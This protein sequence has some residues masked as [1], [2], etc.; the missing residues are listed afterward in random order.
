MKRFHLAAAGLAY[1]LA[2]AAMAV[3]TPAQYNNL[4]SATGSGTSWSTSFAAYCTT[5]TAGCAAGGGTDY[6][7]TMTF[8]SNGGASGPAVTLSAWGSTT[9]STSSTIQ[10]ASIQNYGNPNG[11]GITSQSAGELTASH[12]PDSTSPTYQH[13]IDNTTAYESLM[14][15]FA[16]AVTLNSITVGFTGVDAD[17]TILEYTGSGNP[18][19]ALT[20]ESYADLLLNGWRIVNNLMNMG[21]NSTNAVSGAGIVASQY[22]MVGAY[23]PIGTNGPADANPDSFKITGFSATRSVPEPGSLALFGITGVAFAASRRRR[24][25]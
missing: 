6:G 1:S 10:R 13:A 3:T 21:S 19:A 12:T 5:G 2:T 11:F 15:S 7:S 24:K 20:G 4:E 23:M 14:L 25:A 17:A 18:T 9:L 16:S 8:S 22:W